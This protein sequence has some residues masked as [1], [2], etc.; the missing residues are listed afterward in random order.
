[1]TRRRKRKLTIEQTYALWQQGIPDDPGTAQGRRI[2]EALQ[3]E[4][5]PRVLALLREGKLTTEPPSEGGNS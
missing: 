5:D 2:D 3:R 4:L 1:M